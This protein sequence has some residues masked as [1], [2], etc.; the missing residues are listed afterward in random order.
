MIRGLSRTKTQK[1]Q[2]VAPKEMRLGE[3]LVR[4]KLIDKRTLRRALLTQRA[5][6]MPLGQILIDAAQISHLNL[7]R[8]LLEQNWRSQ[9][10]WII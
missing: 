4:H 3:I 6:R 1:I 10:M 9:G 5:T 7:D 8:A 2:R